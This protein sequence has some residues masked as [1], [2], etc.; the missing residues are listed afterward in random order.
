MGRRPRAV[1]TAVEAWAQRLQKW[2]IVAWPLLQRTAAA[3]VAWVIA[4]QVAGSHDPFFAPLSAVIALNAPL[5]ERGRNALRLVLGVIIGIVAGE[6]ALFAFGA[7]YPTLAVA[8]FVA[9]AAARA[10]GGAPIMIAQA[11]SGAILTVIIADGEVGANRLMDALIGGGVALVFSQ[12]LFSPEPVRLLRR[13]E[14]A[15]LR[16]MADGLDLTAQAL[17]ADD[18]ALAERA[19][20]SLR[21]QR[22]RL[23]E[24]ARLR[25]AGGRVARHSAVWRSQLAPAVQESEDAGHLDLLGGSCLTLARVAAS[26]TSSGRSAL[27]PSVREFAET[28]ANL[29]DDLGDR[30]NRQRAA[31]RALDVV[32]RLAGSDDA[33]RSV[34]SEVLAAVRMVAT[35]LMTFAGVDPEE[36]LDAVREGTGEFRV[37]AP[38][39]TPRWPFDWRRWRPG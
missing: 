15:A 25:R 22:D 32:R 23:A 28:L 18:E 9:M 24:L 3:L 11:A 12:V 19:V 16:G 6:L 10:L 29:A 13:A 17:E 7:G 34:P 33:A 30:S 2:G 1:V 8:V 14:S 35:D 21:G 37:P 36:A 31:D 38:P 26:T 39:S 20:S 5:G 27:A 4:R